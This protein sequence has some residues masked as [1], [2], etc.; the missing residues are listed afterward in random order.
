MQSNS[1]RKR[2]A[3]STLSDSFR[4]AALGKRPAALRQLNSQLL[5]IDLSAQSAQGLRLKKLMEM[6]EKLELG[7]RLL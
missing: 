1:Q 4:L 7:K 6:R 3:Y 2:L 5:E